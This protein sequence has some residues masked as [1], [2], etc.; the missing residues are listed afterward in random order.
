MIILI[1]IGVL[2][3]LLIMTVRRFLWNTFVGKEI[4]KKI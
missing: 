2:E 3:V 1:V 4:L